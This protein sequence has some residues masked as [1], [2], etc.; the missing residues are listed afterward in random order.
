[1]PNL[2]STSTV[3]SL[4][5]CYIYLTA[6]RCHIPSYVRVCPRQTDRNREGER[7][8]ETGMEQLNGGE[9][10]AREGEGRSGQDR[11]VYAA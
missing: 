10:K 8:R 2:T 1:M 9:G 6:L 5:F 3:L 11:R 7:E 4:D